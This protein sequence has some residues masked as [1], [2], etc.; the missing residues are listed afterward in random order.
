MELIIQRLLISVEGRGRAVPP[1]L[2]ADALGREC[3]EV[4]GDGVD[5]S[6]VLS[7]WFC[8]PLFF[9]RERGSLCVLRDRYGRQRG[10]VRGDHEGDAG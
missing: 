10:G 9:A 3:S 1:A 7:G 5:T 4:F 8:G 6:T 2:F